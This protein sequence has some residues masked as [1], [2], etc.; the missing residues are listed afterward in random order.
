[1]YKWHCPT[2]VFLLTYLIEGGHCGSRYPN[3]CVIEQ[4]GYIYIGN[5]SLTCYYSYIADI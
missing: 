1:M 4:I 3:K 2:Q 5:H